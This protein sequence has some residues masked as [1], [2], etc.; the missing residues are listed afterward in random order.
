[1]RRTEKRKAWVGFLFALAIVMFVSAGFAHSL[2]EAGF[3]VLT[4]LGFLVA[5]FALAAIEQ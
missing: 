4:A 1:M 2:G 3:R 5:S